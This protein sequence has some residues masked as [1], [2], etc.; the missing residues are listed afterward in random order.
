MLSRLK[1]IPTPERL[2]RLAARGLIVLQVLLAILI[3]GM[4]NNLAGRHY[5]RWHWEHQSRRQLSNQTLRILDAMPGRIRMTALI[6]PSNPVFHRVSILLEEY[7]TQGDKVSVEI[8]HPDRDMARAEECIRQYEL[9]GGECIVIETGGRHRAIP[10]ADLVVSEPMPEHPNDV[11][12]LFRG[13]QLLSGALQAFSQSTWPAVYFTQGHGEHSPEDFDRHRGYSHIAARLRDANLEV[14]SLALG[15]TRAI[16]NNCAL[17]ILAGPTREFLPF[18]IALI[19]DYLN[20]KGRVLALLDARIRTGLEPL[21]RDWGVDLTD[22]IIV[23]DALTLSGR[24]LYITDYSDHPITAPLQGLASVFYLPRS[25][26]P[27]QFYAGGDKPVITPLFTSTP[28]G[29]AESTPDD[30][31]PSFDPQ[32]DLPGPVPLAVAIERGPIPGVHSQIRPTRLVVVG[33]SDFAANGSLAGANSD[34]FLNAV[35]WLLE[36]EDL[37]S[38][39]AQPMTDFQIV[40]NARQLRCCFGLIV[41][42]WPAL[43]AAG[44]LIAGWR[45]RT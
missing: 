43:A 10:V 4:L 30:P 42:L 6:R 37:L 40:V 24:D 20:H 2:R 34:F 25:I 5:Q 41:V 18:E 14:A 31:A 12:Q 3:F 29:W 21:F 35:H 26:R 33:D 19:R 7:A 36:R 15:E 28:N 9:P 1:I 44:G 11:R 16:P 27:R 13:E 32:A 38:L 39:P 8:I 45:R 23:D 22:D 17:L